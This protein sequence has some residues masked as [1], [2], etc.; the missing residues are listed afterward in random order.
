[1]SQREHYSHSL[2]HGREEK[3]VGGFVVI[4]LVV[5]V[6]AFVINSR[7]LGVFENTIAIEL[8]SETAQGITRDTSIRAAGMQIGRVTSVTLTDSHEFLIHGRIFERH[9]SMLRVDSEASIGSLSMLGRSSI[10][11]SVGSPGLAQLQPGHRMRLQPGL[12]VDELI[13]MAAPLVDNVNTA[14]VQV[15]SL[16]QSIEPQQ[17]SRTLAHSEQ[18]LAEM[19]QFI[20]GLQTEGSLVHFLLH[21][22]Q[23]AGQIEANLTQLASLL[24]ASTQRLNYIDDT[25]PRVHQTM[26]TVQLA[27]KQSAE[28]LAQ[29]P[30]LLMELRAL[31][32]QSQLLLEQA[33][34]TW[35]LSRHRQLPAPAVIEGGAFD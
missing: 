3:I 10:E 25:M 13:A 9:F 30:E 33:S 31:T 18:L 32:E 29:M 20:N 27:T 1:M 24:A 6:L 22:T 2:K 17:I 11:F 5:L 23:L 7:T 8:T 12:A 16:L 19:N 34:H 4:A 35:P 26:D 21:D 28:V 15:N 14:L